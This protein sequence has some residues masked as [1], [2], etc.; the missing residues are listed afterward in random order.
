MDKAVPLKAVKFDQNSAL[1]PVAQIQ[2]EQLAQFLKKAPNAVAE[3]D[4]DVAELDN[5]LAYSLSLERGNIVKKQLVAMGVDDNRIIISAYGNA[6][7]KHGTPE[8]VSI[9]FR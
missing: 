3:I 2:L 9:Q 7:T 6:N 5:T 1:T 4:I 8:G